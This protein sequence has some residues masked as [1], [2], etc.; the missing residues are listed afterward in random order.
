MVPA[1]V[2]RVVINLSLV[3]EID[4]DRGIVP[5]VIPGDGYRSSADAAGGQQE[6]AGNCQCYE[7]KDAF[8]NGFLFPTEMGQM[9]C[10][11]K[12][13]TGGNFLIQWMGR[14]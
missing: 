9:L 1:A 13:D 6:T 5:V 8:H 2:F 7:E 12:N 4:L 3:I 10:L 11:H 14:C